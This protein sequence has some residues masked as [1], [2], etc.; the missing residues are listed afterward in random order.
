[1]KNLL[2]VLILIF[3]QSF[4]FAQS[5]VKPSLKNY[6]SQDFRS[7]LPSN[8]P[9]ERLKSYSWM[10]PTSK[11]NLVTLSLPDTIIEYH[12]ADTTRS[13]HTYDENGNF[14]SWTGQLYVN[15]V[16]ENDDRESYTYDEKGN[17]ITYLYEVWE[18]NNWIGDYR[19]F[20]TYDEFG[21]ET[22]YF[23][24]EWTDSS[25]EISYQSRSTNTYDN[26]RNL[27]ST[28][29]L[30]I[31]D[32][33]L[34]NAR[35]Y[36]YSYDSIGNLLTILSYNYGSDPWLYEEKTTYTYDSN[37]NVITELSQ[38]YSL[39]TWSNG[40]LFT[41]IYNADGSVEKR[42]YQNLDYNNEP[43][44]TEFGTTT[45]E[46]DSNGNLL[47]IGESEIYTYDSNGNLLTWDFLTLNS[48]LNQWEHKWSEPCRIFI[49]TTYSG[50][51]WNFPVQ[52]FG[53]GI[54]FYTY[55]AGNK[56][57]F[58]WTQV[59]ITG[60]ND[61]N[62]NNIITIYPN[63]ASTTLNIKGIENQNI[64]KVYS[65]DG[66][67]MLTIPIS[68]NNQVLNVSQLKSGIYI[69]KIETA[70]GIITKKFVKQ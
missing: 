1:M 56:M 35:R 30:K 11:T 33:S 3:Q 40:N 20:T 55:G 9:M 59:E 34:V 46:Y 52:K 23:S 19:G 49:K 47:S 66:K 61:I 29:E 15:P 67:Q 21:N 26:N 54:L 7:H 4:L 24:E 32:D 60:I 27:L 42:N 58:H 64:A 63:P 22:E 10:N 70:K 68:E 48:D 53:N 6:Y 44:A 41:Y 36:E 50:E 62:E 43:Y 39:N 5:V 31:I 65:M 14:L 2:F 17:P 13:I 16:W 37:N 12:I 25:W 69:L 45:Y 51:I 57:I 38:Y 8:S 28:E 18:N